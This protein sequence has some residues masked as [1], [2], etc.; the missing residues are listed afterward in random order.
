MPPRSCSDRRSLA[1][2]SI[3]MAFLPLIPLG[4]SAPSKVEFPVMK[5][6]VS[7]GDAHDDE[8]AT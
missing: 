5:A 8:E 6:I 4:S 3:L 7:S 1:V 2:G